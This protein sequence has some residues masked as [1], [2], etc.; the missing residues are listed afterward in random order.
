MDCYMGGKNDN[1]KGYQNY[2]G[3]SFY[4]GGKGGRGGYANPN[5]GN[6]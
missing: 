1:Y 5:F 2:G 6:N 4:G 3:Q